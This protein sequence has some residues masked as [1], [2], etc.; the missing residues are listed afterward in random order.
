MC[1]PPRAR[2]PRAD[3]G[4]PDSPHGRQRDG[5]RPRVPSRP[6]RSSAGMPT[7]PSPALCAPGG[8]KLSAPVIDYGVSS[9]GWVLGQKS[10]R[11]KVFQLTFRSHK[12]DEI[13]PINSE[14]QLNCIKWSGMSR[15]PHPLYELPIRRMPPELQVFVQSREHLEQALQ[16]GGGRFVPEVVENELLRIQPPEVAPAASGMR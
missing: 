10:S 6:K 1:R 7:P 16:D 14:R 11:V 3:P 2:H 5:G 9:R 13:P 4:Q 8:G 12:G 15:G